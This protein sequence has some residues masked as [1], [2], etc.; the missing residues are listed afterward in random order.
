MATATKHIV[1]RLE[2]T[3]QEARDLK[4]ALQEFPSDDPTDPLFHELSRS[5]AELDEEGK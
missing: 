2:M 3:V 4:D 5:L 1:V